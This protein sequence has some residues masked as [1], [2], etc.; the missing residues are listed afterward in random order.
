MLQ[1][2]FKAASSFQ[3]INLEFNKDVKN[4]AFLFR[5]KA[6][7]ERRGDDVPNQALADKIVLTKANA[8]AYIIAKRLIEGICNY[9]MESA[10]TITPI[11]QM[12]EHYANREAAY[13]K[14]MTELH[15]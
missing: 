9:L 13:F 15:K 11:A 6:K 2:I 4:P 12:L 14:R 1:A 7:T 8:R 5:V 3:D 10:K